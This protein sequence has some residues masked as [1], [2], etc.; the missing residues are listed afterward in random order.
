M[1][2]EGLEGPGSTL[3][4]VSL[5]LRGVSEVFLEGLKN[6]SWLAGFMVTVDYTANLLGLGLRYNQDN[7]LSI[8]TD[9]L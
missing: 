9:F 4:N 6:V 3:K 1:E 5:S 2:L 8:Y 7:I